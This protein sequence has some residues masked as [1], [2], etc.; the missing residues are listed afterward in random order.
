MHDHAVWD[1]PNWPGQNGCGR[2]RV[3]EVGGEREKFV[4]NQQ[5]TEGR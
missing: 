1:S 3:L 2:R 5:V 4:D